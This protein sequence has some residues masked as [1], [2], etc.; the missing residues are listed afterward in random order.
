MRLAKRLPTFIELKERMSPKG[1]A[2]DERQESSPLLLGDVR[3]E[4]DAIE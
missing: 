2:R 3:D 4:E 1:K